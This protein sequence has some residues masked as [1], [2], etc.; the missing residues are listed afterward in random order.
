[1][2]V[3]GYYDFN[4]YRMIKPYL[5]IGIGYGSNKGN[6]SETPKV[7]VNI[8]GGSSKN[9][10][11]WNVGFGHKFMVN[12]RLGLDFSYRYVDLGKTK[13]KPSATVPGSQPSSQKIKAHEIM[14]GVIVNL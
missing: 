9:N 14:G 11:V 2:F 5:S 8:Y 4:L 7:G 13:T 1:M 3:N 12:R 10:L 6:L